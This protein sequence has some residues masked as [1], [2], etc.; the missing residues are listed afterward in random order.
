MPSKDT[1]APPRGRDYSAISTIYGFRFVE[2]I[3]PED[4]GGIVGG[5]SPALPTNAYE[6]LGSP[7]LPIC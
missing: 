3:I 2:V 5:G 1:T 7:G 6:T 4:T